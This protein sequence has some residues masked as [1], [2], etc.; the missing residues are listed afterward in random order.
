MPPLAR[1]LVD[2]DLG[3]LR[4]IAELWDLPLSAPN[5]REAAAQ[6]ARGMLEAERV[7]RV[8]A[9]LPPEAQTALEVIRRAGG[10]AP[11]AAFAR[12]HGTVRAMGP[13]R[14]DR[15][16]PW[17]HAPSPAE[18][19]WYC[20][21]IAHGFFEAEGGPQE[22]AFIP[23]DLLPLIP[24]PEA[25]APPPPPGVAAEAPASFRPAAPLVAEDMVTL[26]AYAQ[27]TPLRLEGGTLTTRLPAT[28]RRFLR[29]PEALDL[30]FQ[31][32][33]DLNLLAD[34]PLKPD[35]AVARAFIEQPAAHQAR[36]LAEAWRTSAGWNDLRRLPGLVCEGTNWRND[37][38]TARAALL[39][40]LAEVPPRTWWSLAAFVAAV[41]ERAPDFQRPAGDYDSWYVR[42]AAT[43]AYLRGFAHWDRVDGAL[44]R[45]VITG[46]LRWLGMVEAA[47]G[48]F[49]VTAA[50]AAWLS[51]QPVPEAAEARQVH[52]GLDGVIRAPLTLRP[53]D[54]FRIARV[55]KWLSLEGEA[56]RY[57]LTPTSL[58]R[59]ARQGI[60][61]D[62]LIDFLR[63]IAEPPGLPPS[64]LTALQRWARNGAEAAIKEVTVLRLK[65]AEVLEALRRTPRV[66]DL[67][68]EALSPTAIEVRA[69]DAERLRGLLTELGLLVD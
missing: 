16:Q 45:W 8:V 18:S 34:H 2:Y 65:S 61:L 56:Y 33:L 62:R 43:G 60:P 29:E 35:P 66:K 37:P 24:A 48:V 57:R 21:L 11:L 4:L 26:L 63:Q 51:G 50:G 69:A 19:L 49:R 23:E 64:L 46:P 22:H 15:E 17:R 55:A 67:L 13:A 40:L 1:V 54:R 68:G 12:V 39:A 53:T 28:V 59:A 10:R 36:A 47:P 41:K 14:R 20:A 31:L 30:C 25:P 6:V 44:L 9:G 38:V 3:L 27:L 42:E 58:K 52:L 7:A 5:Q 32:A